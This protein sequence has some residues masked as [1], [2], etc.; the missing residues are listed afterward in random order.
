METI[1]KSLKDRAINFKGSDY[2]QVKDRVLYLAENYDW[3]YEIYQDYEYFAENKMRVVKTKLV[4]RDETHEDNCI[5]EW[6]AQEIEWSSF[7]NK[8]S[9]LENASTSSLGR[10]IACLWIGVIDSF[11]SINEIEK[12][13]NRAKVQEKEEKDITKE[14]PFP[15]ELP[16]FNDKEFEQLKVETE[17]MKEKKTS[18]ELIKSLETKYRLS[19]AMKLKVADLRA[20]L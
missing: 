9:A 7:I 8:T 15:T 18:E 10:A 1:D 17:W 4:I 5:Y 3:R 2:V 14:W 13:E 12:A 16:W 20:S 6:L 11:A 19:K